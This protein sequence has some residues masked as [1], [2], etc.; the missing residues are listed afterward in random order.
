MPSVAGAAAGLTHGVYVGANTVK[1]FVLGV[2][3]ADR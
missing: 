1:W 3:E 2:C